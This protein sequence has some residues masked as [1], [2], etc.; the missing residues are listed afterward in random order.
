MVEGTEE[1]SDRLNELRVRL[2]LSRILHPLLIAPDKPRFDSRM[3]SIVR[4]I[5]TVLSDVNRLS[6]VMGYEL[7]VKE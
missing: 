4:Q 5:A 7:R 6:H 3:N 1:S 2:P